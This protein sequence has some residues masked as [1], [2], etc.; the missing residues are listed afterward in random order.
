MSR[1]RIDSTSPRTAA[2]GSDDHQHD[3]SHARAA[4]RE[5]GAP[6]R[7]TRRHVLLPPRFEHHR[8]ARGSPKYPELRL[9]RL[10]QIMPES[11]QNGASREECPESVTSD[12]SANQSPAPGRVPLTLLRGAAG[13]DE[14]ERRACARDGQRSDDRRWRA[15][16]CLRSVEAAWAGAGRLTGL[17]SQAVRVERLAHQ[18]WRRWGA[19]GGGATRRG[20]RA[21]WRA[22]RWPSGGCTGDRGGRPLGRPRRGPSAGRCL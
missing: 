11:C 17:E 8:E 21:R 9:S 5:A 7:T 15:G 3:D 10:A 16:E 20:E 22:T 1:R 6:R 14:S 18:G 4:P 12:G 19:W 13:A 2:S